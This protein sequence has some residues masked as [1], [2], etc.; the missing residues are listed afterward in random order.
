[1]KKYFMGVLIITFLAGLS[2]FSGT[3]SVEKTKKEI[4]T[5]LDDS[6]KGWND[7]NIDKYMECY[8]KSDKMRFAGNG[9]FNFGWE[10]T[11]K[12]Y[13][14]RYPDKNAMGQLSFSGMDI[15]ILSEDSAYVFGRWTL[16][17][18]EAVRSGLY[19]LIMRKFKEGWRIIHDHS[20]SKK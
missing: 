10:N 7:G 5:V 12:R 11:M 2:I 20:S 6:E 19:T 4:S 16:L 9:S 13:K 15:T 18:P 14:K 3:I 8:H 1:M 17:Y